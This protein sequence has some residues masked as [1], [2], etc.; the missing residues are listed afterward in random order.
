MKALI[1]ATSG[2]VQQIAR[3]EEPSGTDFSC[4]HPDL[5]MSA[6]GYVK[7]TPI[8]IPD[9]LLPSR[10]QCIKATLAGLAEQETELRRQFESKL[11]LIETARQNILALPHVTSTVP[12]D[13]ITF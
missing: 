2:A 3:G 1:W 13:D 4:T 12:A 11:A 5:D 7:V 8:E 10:E 9:E 6:Y